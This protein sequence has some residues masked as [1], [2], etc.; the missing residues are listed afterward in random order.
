MMR[1]WERFSSAPCA[2]ARRMPNPPDSVSLCSV[3]L[4]R[5]K[6]SALFIGA[7]AA[8]ASAVESIVGCATAFIALK[9]RLIPGS[10]GA[11][12]SRAGWVAPDLLGVEFK[13][14]APE[15]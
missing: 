7:A 11:A 14:K 12:S 5:F 15:P 3:T 13:S 9:V 6:G 2:S 8:S 1:G 10:R 4:R